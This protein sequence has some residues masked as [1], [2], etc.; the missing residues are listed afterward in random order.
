MHSN[1]FGRSLIQDTK[2]S[3]IE[4]LHIE[5]DLL[6]INRNSDDAFTTTESS[7]VHKTESC[8]SL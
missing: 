6:F 3:E 1:D 2:K 7:T 4:R 8:L 5:K